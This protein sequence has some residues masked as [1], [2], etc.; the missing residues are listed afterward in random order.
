VLGTLG[1]RFIGGVV[2]GTVVSA[3][4]PEE[5]VRI[6][7]EHNIDV[8]QILVAEF[9]EEVAAIPDFPPI[10]AENDDAEFCFEIVC[11][12]ESPLLSGKLKPSLVV[13]V[14]LNGRDGKKLWENTADIYNSKGKLK[15]YK[16]KEYVENPE[17]LREVFGQACEI[18]ARK[19]AKN[20]R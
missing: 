3:R 20:L 15:V 13:T 16:H 8:G 6:M 7:E 1:G 14:Q 18:I 2:A 4:N 12:L 19:F 17:H 9:K 5:I 10:V 11:G